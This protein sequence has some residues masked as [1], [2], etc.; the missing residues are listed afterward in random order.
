MLHTHSMYIY[1]LICYHCNIAQ[2]VVVLHFVNFDNFLTFPN[3][4]ILQVKHNSGW[5]FKRLQ[6]H[7]TQTVSVTSKTVQTNANLYFIK[8]LHSPV[9]ERLFDCRKWKPAQ[10][11]E[12]KNIVQFCSAV[13]CHAAPKQHPMLKCPYTRCDIML[14]NGYNMLEMGYKEVHRIIHIRCDIRQGNFLQQLLYHGQGWQFL[15][16]HRKNPEISVG[17]N[18]PEEIGFFHF[19][20]EEMEETKNWWNVSV[21]AS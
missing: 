1:L 15:P 16:D 19:I 5:N 17:K 8:C 11:L 3:C 14:E 20:L 10:V 4:K 9:S 18:A 7:V 12:L 21:V 13:P 2:V 6:T